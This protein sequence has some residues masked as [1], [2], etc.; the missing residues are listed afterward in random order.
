[1]IKIHNK[2]GARPI[3]SL[4]SDD[5]GKKT[6]TSGCT[7]KII[8]AYLRSRANHGWCEEPGTIKVPR[9]PSR[10]NLSTTKLQ[11]LKG[12]FSHDQNA[13]DQT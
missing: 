1:M 8:D 3:S 2:R 12:G 13:L 9:A 7:V 6:S 4:T 10:K 5:N 11:K